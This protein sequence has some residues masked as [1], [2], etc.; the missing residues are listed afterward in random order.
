MITFVV[1][2]IESGNII[3]SRSNYKTKISVL[4]YVESF[5]ILPKSTEKEMLIFIQKWKSWLLCLKINAE[6][7]GKFHT[8]NTASTKETL[9]INVFEWLLY[10]FY[11][12]KS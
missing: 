3:L 1:S 6:N 5:S 12:R 11:Y 9:H 10:T 4:E 8:D 2:K 7:I